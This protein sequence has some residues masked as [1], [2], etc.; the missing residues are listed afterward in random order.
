M[1]EIRSFLNFLYN[2][3]IVSRE[4]FEYILN[5]CQNYKKIEDVLE[6][7]VSSGDFF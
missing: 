6:E 4:L 7:L 3:K 5:N 1:S 2:K